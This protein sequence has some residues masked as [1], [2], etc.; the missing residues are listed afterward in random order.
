MDKYKII[1]LL[2]NIVATVDHG[3]CFYDD[4]EFDDYMNDLARLAGFSRQLFDKNTEG[5]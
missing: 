1:Q 4:Q 3:E 5:E 2:E